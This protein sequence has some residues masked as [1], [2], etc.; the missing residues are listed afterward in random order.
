M[1]RIDAADLKSWLTAEEDQNCSS[2]YTDVKLVR[3]GMRSV[4]TN[5][6]AEDDEPPF[7]NHRT[8][9]TAEEFF[10]LTQKFFTSYKRADVLAILKRCV[11]LISSGVSTCGFP[12]QE[13]SS[14]VSLYT[15]G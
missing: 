2:R 8:S 4:A 5:E 3:N 10:K 13:E 1:D 11:V 15:A 14:L 6:I 12:S 7:D 9:I